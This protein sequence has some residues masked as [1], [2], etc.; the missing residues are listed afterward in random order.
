MLKYALVKLKLKHKYTE[1]I[2]ETQNNN[3]TNDGSKASSY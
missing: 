3:N 1:A 2:K